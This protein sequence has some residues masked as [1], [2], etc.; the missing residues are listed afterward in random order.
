MATKALGG[1]VRAAILPAHDGNLEAAFNDLCERFANLA[2]E[3][4]RADRMRSY[5]F[6]REGVP[7][8]G[9]IDD[10]PEPITDDWIKTGTGSD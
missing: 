3:L 9:K 7:V 10:V 1:H 6:A 2:L 5:A 8:T 4:D